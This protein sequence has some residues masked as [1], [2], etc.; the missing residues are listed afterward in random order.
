MKVPRK[1][2]QR[3]ILLLLEATQCFCRRFRHLLPGRRWVVF[4]LTCGRMNGRLPFSSFHLTSACH[5]RAA[6]ASG[7]NKRAITKC[8]ARSH[9]CIVRSCER[10]ECERAFKTVTLFWQMGV[11]SLFSMPSHPKC[12]M[13]VTPRHFCSMS[14]RKN[15]ITGILVC[16]RCIKR[17]K[18]K[19]IASIATDTSAGP[20]RL[21]D[22]LGPIV[23]AGQPGL[24]TFRQTVISHCTQ[25]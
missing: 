23:G 12:A 8:S 6:A 4:A 11:F 5:R 20:V 18:L 7:R 21:F 10:Q 24:I 3:K 2:I 13:P 17:T 9:P 16:K 19:G 22:V 14:Y 25:F 1:Y 15:C